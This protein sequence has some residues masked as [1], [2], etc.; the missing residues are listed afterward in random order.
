M[1]QS[2]FRAAAFAFAA[3][4]SVLVAAAGEVRTARLIVAVP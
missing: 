4:L 1:S 3:S 2:A